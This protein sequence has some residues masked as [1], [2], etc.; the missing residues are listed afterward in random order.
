MKIRTTLW[1]L[2]CF[3]LALT[4]AFCAREEKERVVTEN[5]VP[6]AVLEVFTNSYPDAAVKQFGEEIEDGQTFYEISFAFEGREM[7]VLYK[8]DGKVAEIEEA[9]SEQEL[10]DN[11]RQAITKEFD[12]CSL[13][14]IE[15]I[16]KAGKKFFEVKLTNTKDEKRWE[17]IFSD[18][19]ELIKKEEM[20]EEED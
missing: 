20:G 10:A 2:L 4:L 3:S 6:Q 17:L 8:P 14:K 9:I 18:A 13:D 5:E 11:I 19:G 1:L 12:R 7:E 16:D 15:K